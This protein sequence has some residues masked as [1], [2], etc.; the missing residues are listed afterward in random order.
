MKKSILIFI[1][2]LVLLGISSC[3]SNI[4]QQNNEI[5]ATH[6]D[7]QASEHDSITK[8]NSI[9][10]SLKGDID[11]IKVEID[12]LNATIKTMNA[13]IQNLNSPD[14]IQISILIVIILL[15]LYVLKIA[16]D[17]KEQNQN[18]ESEV[19][20]TN[21]SLNNLKLKFDQLQKDVSE[22]KS[23]KS[24]LNKDIDGLKLDIN[25]SLKKSSNAENK[26]IEPQVIFKTIY[27]TSVSKGF[28]NELSHSSEGCLFSIKQ[29][30]EE[31]ATFDII[32]VQKI[33][34]STNWRDAVEFKCINCKIE[35]A[36]SHEVESFGECEKV[37]NV[38]WKV[39]KKLKIKI[40]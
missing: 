27:A 25:R 15:F 32:S 16:R 19:N 11:A 31:K 35:D 7:S 18:I 22:I 36:K 21:S 20:N 34:S 9:E 29:K 10:D 23:A 24:R 38:D 2:I 28:F 30:S 40:Y 12:S 26:Q 14:W 33:S 6:I 4:S 17:I 5:S 1:G 13:E 8:T 39:V 37:N 3:E